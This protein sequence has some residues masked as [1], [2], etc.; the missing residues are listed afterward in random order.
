MYFAAKRTHSLEPTSGGFRVDEAMA[1][2]R[3]QNSMRRFAAAALFFAAAAAMG[4][5][6][7][8][9]PDLE[10]ERVDYWVEQF[11]HTAE[12]RKKVAAGFERKPRVQALITKLPGETRDFVPAIVALKRIGRNR[13]KYGF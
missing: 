1:L 5:P 7:D 11:S 9:L 8:V 2:H 4:G 3:Q 10:H 12:Y 13:A 6:R